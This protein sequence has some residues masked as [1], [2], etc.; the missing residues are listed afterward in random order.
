MSVN[1]TNTKLGCT[2][3]PASKGPF[4]WQDFDRGEVASQLAHT[5]DLGC[6]VVRLLLPWETFQPQETVLHMPAFDAFG[7]VLDAA[8]DAAIKVVPVLF[9][10]HLFNHRF[11]PRWLMDVGTPGRQQM[12]TIS[13]GWEHPGGVKN[14]YETRELLD[15]QQ[16]LIRELIGFYSQHPAVHAWDIGGNGLLAAAP[17]SPYRD[18]EAVHHWLSLL[19]ETVQ[20]ADESR[21]PVWCST[22]DT[23][24]TMSEAPRL[25]L[26]AELGIICALET[27]PFVHTSAAGGTDADFLAYVWLLA[28]TLADAAVACASTGLPTSPEGGDTTITVPQRGRRPRRRVQVYAEEKQARFLAQAVGNAVAVAL[29]FIC[30]ATYADVPPALW[31]EPP[32]D[33]AVAPRYMGLVRSDEDEKA[34]ADVWR[35]RPA[36]PSRAD[37]EARS[38]AVDLDEFVAEPQRCFREWYSRFRQGE[39]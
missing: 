19:Q 16:T 1:E 22:P 21:H 8:L 35:R 27:Y 13:D 32:F 4:F 39:L 18:P 29:S 31:E 14:L 37:L 28:R 12:R 9:V 20:E 11:L 23:V 38:L 10:G 36:E 5:A 33:V 24:L 3:W 15:A 34:A 30:N 6:D 26:L 17:A 25:N 2:Y 7:E